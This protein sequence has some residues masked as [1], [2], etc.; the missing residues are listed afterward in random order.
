MTE[1]TENER[2]QDPSR[3]AMLQAGAAGAVA[4]GSLGAGLTSGSRAAA[5]N[6]SSNHT[7]IASCWVHIG[8]VVPFSGRMWSPVPFEYRARQVAEVGFQGMGLFHDDLAYILEQQAPGSSR[9]DKFRW[10]KDVLD[11]NGLT[12]NEIKFLVNWMVPQGNPLRD[13]EQPIRELLIDAANILRPINLKCGNLGVPVD[14]ATA[15]QGFRELC[16]PACKIDPGIGVIG[17]QI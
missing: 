15:N 14:V 8:P 9:A 11:E 2:P 10:M 17:V 7:L 16:E 12:S 5:Q 1:N 3:R 4:L 13:G 6:A